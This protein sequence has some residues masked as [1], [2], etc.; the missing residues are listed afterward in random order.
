MELSFGNDFMPGI[1]YGGLQPAKETGWHRKGHIFESP[2][3]YIEYGLAQL[4]ALQVWRNSLQHG[5]AKAVAD[6]RSALASGLHPF[7]A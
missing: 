6:Y 5:N 4:G 1:D 7:P 2:F 3:Y